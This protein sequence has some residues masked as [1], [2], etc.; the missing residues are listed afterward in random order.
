[1]PSPKLKLVG[2]PQDLGGGM[3]VTRIFP[4]AQKRMV[5]PFVFFDHMGPVEIGAGQ[6]TDVRPH[7]HI[8]LSTLTYL[9][10]GRMVHR[11]SLGSNVT[12]VPGDVNWM[13]AGNGIV[14]SERAHPDDRQL[15]R[16]LQGFQLWVALPDAQEDCA[17]GFSHTDRADVP[18]MTMPSHE[19]TVVAG[20]AFGLTSPVRISS[21]LILVNIL[22]KPGGG[23][24]ALDFGSFELGIYLLSGALE[25]DG[26]AL[27]PGEM[28][29]LDPHITARIEFSAQTHFIIL[30]GEPF[31][32]PRH[33]WWNMVSTSREKIELARLRWKNGTF[34]K[35]PGET[36]FIPAP[37]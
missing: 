8:G 10:E 35:V 20:T 30:G 2:K 33:L 14:H 4:Q 28:L 24:L 21:P 11:D 25:V 15:T 6:N 9:L 32:T 19:L 34:P 12:I 17:P 7:P 36:E 29:I 18:R 22:S 27:Q 5:G 3:T 37:D 13:T 16:R 23:S 26:Q 1:M 31:T